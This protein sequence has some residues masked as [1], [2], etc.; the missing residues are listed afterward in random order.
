MKEEIPQLNTEAM[1]MS[2]SPACS[3]KKCACL[4]DDPRECY[5]LRYFRHYPAFENEEDQDECPC[6]C[7]S[8]DWDD[9]DPLEDFYRGH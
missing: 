4:A 8:I 5:E 9:P 2:H 1:E 3:D 7:H 6:E